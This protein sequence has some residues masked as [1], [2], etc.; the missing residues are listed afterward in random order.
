M[1][2]RY[3]TRCELKKYLGTRV[4]VSGEIQQ[5]SSCHSH[6]G[7]EYTVACVVHIR[8]VRSGEYLT[9]HVW[10]P[11]AFLPGGV[12]E[13]DIVVFDA[14]VVEYSKGYCGPREGL[15]KER[16]F[17]TDYTLRRVTNA[18]VISGTEQ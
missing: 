10:I 14:E 17:R 18:G 16:P 5:I 9:Q 7:S 6:L 13:G 2:N 11:V 4:R 15:R 3:S 8:H 1:G 12:K